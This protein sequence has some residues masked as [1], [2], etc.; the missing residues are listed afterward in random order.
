MSK[1]KRMLAVRLTVTSPEGGMRE[2]IDADPM[3]LEL[4]S[5]TLPAE[6]EIEP[7]YRNDGDGMRAEL[8][9]GK[10]EDCTLSVGA[11]DY[12]VVSREGKLLKI[13]SKAVNPATGRVGLG[14]R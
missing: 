3:E 8:A 12:R 10:P 4:D 7:R 1:S 11:E 2:A 9:L 6:W 14:R 5:E 13:R